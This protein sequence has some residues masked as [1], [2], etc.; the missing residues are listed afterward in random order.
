MR[1]LSIFLTLGIMLSACTAATTAPGPY[2]TMP[3]SYLYRQQAFHI[4]LY[5]N[6]L[7]PDHKTITDLGAFLATGQTLT[8]EGYVENYSSAE[9]Y[10]IELLVLAF[11]KDGTF[12]GSVVG[13]PKDYI[14]QPEFTSPFIIQM[15]LTGK[16]TRLAIKERY[17]WRER[18]ERH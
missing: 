14:I 6:Y 5:W 13:K 7:D 17:Q 8:V 9:V 15:P 10:D 12:L 16:E 1:W 3:S 4:K 18:Q 2:S 11:D